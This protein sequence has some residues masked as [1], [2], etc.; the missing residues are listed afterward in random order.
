MVKQRLVP[1]IRRRSAFI[2]IELIIALSIFTVA[3]LPV[4]F[5]TLQER[6]LA[7]AYYFRAVALELVDGEMEALF[8]GEW[9][10]LS[11]GRQK[12]TVRGEAASSLPPG[13]FLLTLGDHRLRLEWQPAGR[14]QGGAVVREVNLPA[15]PV[16]PSP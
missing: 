3:M 11:Q 2:T 12:F 6:R 5:S 15:E 10:S 13:Q 9:R 16:P 14:G 8:A 7:R 1:P 4:A